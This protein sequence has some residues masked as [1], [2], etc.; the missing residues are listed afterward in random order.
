MLFFWLCKEGKFGKFYGQVDPQLIMEFLETFMEYREKFFNEVT[1][2]IESRY[3]EWHRTNVVKDRKLDIAVVFKAL[4]DNLTRKEKTREKELPDS[5]ESNTMLHSATALVSNTYGYDDAVLSQMCASW[6]IRYG[7]KPQEYI[8]RT[9][10][11][12][13]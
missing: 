8:N 4:Q 2:E 1:E 5:C 11:T 12:K 7:C 13:K 3:D 10:E 9:K 6:E